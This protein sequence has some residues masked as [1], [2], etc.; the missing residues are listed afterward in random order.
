[1]GSGEF[2]RVECFE[3]ADEQG[4]DSSSVAGGNEVTPALDGVGSVLSSD[5]GTVVTVSRGSGGIGQQ[6]SSVP[7]E[8]FNSLVGEVLL[9][10]GEFDV[11][12]SIGFDLL[13]GGEPADCGIE[14]LLG[15][16]DGIVG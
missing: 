10:S 9:D 7:E 4:F 8:G 14:V 1:M 12:G 15:G 6:S 11:V 13:F 2:E 5:S 16:F 3:V